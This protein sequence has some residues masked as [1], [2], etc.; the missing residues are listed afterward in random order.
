MGAIGGGETLAAPWRVA[1][2]YP[3][4]LSAGP[5]PRGPVGARA[6]EAVMHGTISFRCPGCRAR[7]KAPRELLGQRRTCPGCKTPFVVRVQVP[8]DNGPILVADK[9]A[10]R[11]VRAR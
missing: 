5:F 11:L 7:I 9:E 1:Y 4:P 8:P 10:V 6:S 3:P 2:P